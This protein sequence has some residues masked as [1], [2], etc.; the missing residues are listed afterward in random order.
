[1]S[2]MDEYRF[3]TSE[4]FYV[5]H[6]FLPVR[7]GGGLLSEL[8]E[9]KIRLTPEG[10]M[11]YG[12]WTLL[13]IRFPQLAIDAFRIMP[14]YVHGIFVLDR[15][16]QEKTILEHPLSPN[17]K[18]SFSKIMW[19]LRNS[20]KSNCPGRLGK[21]YFSS[22]LRSQIDLELARGLVKSF[23]DPRTDIINGL[24]NLPNLTSLPYEETKRELDE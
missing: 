2:T 3:L 16:R 7:S 10:K 6:Q 14:E 8:V 19:K 13:P 12:V 22:K 17:A 15:L 5:L 21:E 11:L 9:G 1:M 20:A 24:C 23:E 18:A 4:V